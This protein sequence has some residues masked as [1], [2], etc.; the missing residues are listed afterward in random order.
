MDQVVLPP[1][2]P[3]LDRFFAI[4]GSE[5][6][7]PRNVDTYLRRGAREWADSP[8][9]WGNY[10]YSE[11][12]FALWPIRDQD[13]YGGSFAVG[14][15]SPTPLVIGTT[16]DPATPY[17]SAIGMVRALGNARLLTMNGDGHTAYGRNS[18][19]IDSATNNYLTAGALPARGTVCQ[20]QVPFVAP[21]SA[22]AAAGTS[23]GRVTLPIT[24]RNEVL[25][26]P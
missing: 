13:A 1:G 16:F 7:W 2:D 23:S 26:R 12:P 18:T 5:E 25:R 9:F 24:V 6:Q 11:V 15:T 20:Q 21:Q 4:S 8:H 10:A 17:S 22:P 14:S 19:C 3:S